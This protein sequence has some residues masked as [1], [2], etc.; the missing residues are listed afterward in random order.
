LDKDQIESSQIKPFMLAWK[1]KSE[2]KLA[3]IGKTSSSDSIDEDV[4]EKHRFDFFDNPE[5]I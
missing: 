4:L 3:D 5:I 2:K 1:K